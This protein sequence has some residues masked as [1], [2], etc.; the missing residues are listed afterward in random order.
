MQFGIKLFFHPTPEKIRNL[1]DLFLGAFNLA[2]I[3]ALLTE[4][5]TAGF[6]VMGIG[7][8]CKILSNMCTTVEKKNPKK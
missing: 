7:F 1:G 2:G 4:H 6:I 8:A 5:A 3:S